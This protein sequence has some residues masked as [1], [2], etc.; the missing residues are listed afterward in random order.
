MIIVNSMYCLNSKFKVLDDTVFKNMTREIAKK[1]V[2]QT[3]VAMYEMKNGRPYK[4][5]KLD[6]NI[7]QK[8]NNGLQQFEYY[9]PNIN[10]EVESQ[11][12]KNAAIFA[13]VN[14]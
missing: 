8:L 4:S 1:L 11:I 10:V 3:K 13:I 5:D 9:Y 7:L 12:I 14:F 2:Y 6:K